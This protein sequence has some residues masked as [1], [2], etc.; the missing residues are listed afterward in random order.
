MRLGALGLD[1]ADGDADR[2]VMGGVARQMRL[3]GPCVR[4][5][6]ADTEFAVASWQCLSDL[7]DIGFEFMVVMEAERALPSSIS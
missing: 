7:R 4:T 2:R 5:D 1:V 6:D 3:L